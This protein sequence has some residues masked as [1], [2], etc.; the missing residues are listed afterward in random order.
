MESAQSKVY[1]VST[2]DE[3]RTIEFEETKLSLG[4]QVLRGLLIVWRALA[5]GCLEFLR[6]SWFITKPEK[7][8]TPSSVVVYMNGTLGDHIVHLPVIA[9]LKKKYSSATLT[10][11][12]WCGDF[13]MAELLSAEPYI[14]TIVTLHDHPVVRDGFRFGF[15]DTILESLRCD[16]FVNLSPFGNRGVLGFVLREMI[17][18]RK[19]HARYAIGFHMFSLDIRGI[20]NGL[21][22]YFVVNEPRRAAIVLN[23][24][25]LPETTLGDVLSLNVEERKS[26]QKKIAAMV[27]SPRPIV[28]VNPGAK[29]MIK[30]WP[31]ERFAAIASWLSKEFNAHIIITGIDSEKGLAERIVAE[32]GGKAVSLAGETSMLELIELLRMSAL[33][34]T[35]DTGTMHVAALL[36]RPMV[37]IFG[38]RISPTHWFP[39]SHRARILFSFAPSSYSFSDEGGADESI[40]RIQVDDVKQAVRD[41]FH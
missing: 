36:Q 17:F 5:N 14:D 16:V 27:N 38:T 4:L 20:L 40:L 31:A 32:S 25:D 37:A 21:K 39:N 18:A 10:V 1:S 15:S 9:G 28:V 26:V 34:V 7:L 3:A 24:L 41:V 8:G 13:P 6:R 22:H 19:I 35:N 23:D 33:C 11:V 12:S 30:C 29:F 2:L